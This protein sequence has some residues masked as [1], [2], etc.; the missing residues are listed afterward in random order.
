MKTHYIII[1]SSYSR[2][3]RICLEVLDDMDKAQ[4]FI[5][6]IIEECGEDVSL[7]VHYLQTEDGKWETVQKENSFFEDIEKVETVE[8]FIFWIKK[9]RS[10]S[11]L[12]I[13]RYILSKMSCT[14]LKL[15]KLLY[16]C[17]AEYLLKEKKQL[18]ENE[19]IC[20][21]PRGPVVSSICNKYYG[22]T[23]SLREDD[24][25]SEKEKL[26]RLNKWFKSK[27]FAE[28]NK[29]I[30]T[31]QISEKQS[32]MLPARSRI[33]FAEDGKKR[34]ASI[35]AT[36]ARYASLSDNELVHLTHR[37]NTPWSIT[38]GPHDT[39]GIIT[40]ECIIGYHKNETLRSTE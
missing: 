5:D 9:D 18:F 19:R 22:R 10:L 31:E 38:R 14:H 1:S 17:Y 40:D 27:D 34:A 28:K 3:V 12:D 25:L 6:K 23:D 7:S 26:E 32:L 20:A 15:Q 4:S 8:G 37:E 29:K 39:W 21:L 30:D 33:L 16:F 36:L 2:G 11:A 24:V 35:D 13:T